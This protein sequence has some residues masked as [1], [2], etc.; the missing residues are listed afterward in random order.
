MTSS[1][2]RAGSRPSSPSSRTAPPRRSHDFKSSLVGRCSELAPRPARS[3][4]PFPTAGHR[5]RRGLVAIGGGAASAC[6][7]GVLALGVG[8]CAADRAAPAGHRPEPARRPG[9][10]RHRGRR[11]HRARS[12]LTLP[13]APGRAPRG[14]P[15]E[16]CS[17]SDEHQPDEQAPEPSRREP[18][19]EPARRRSRPSRSPDGAEPEPS[20]RRQPRGPALRPPRRRAAAPA[21]RRSAAPTASSRARA[22]RS[23][24]PPHRSHGPYSPGGPRRS[25][26]APAGGPVPGRSGVLRSRSATR[27][28]DYARPVP[29]RKLPLWVVARRGRPRAGRRPPRRPRRR[30]PAGRA[31]L[32]AR[33]RRQRPRRR[34]HPVRGAARR[35]QRVGAGR[36]AGAAAQ[37]RADRRRVRRPGGRRHRLRLRARPRGPRRHQQPRRRLGRRGRRPDRR[38]RPRGRAPRGHR[39][40]PQLGLRPRRAATSRT[41]RASSP[42]PWA[43]PRCC[44][45]ATRSSPSARRWG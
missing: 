32:A 5:P 42:P 10:P 37:H 29:P 3:P 30:R 43:R 28:A 34:T 24:Q 31:G 25:R 19:A 1:S 7:V 9:D 27:R 21:R 36:G 16:D 38:H 4:A 2:T 44:A 17:V 45:S 20:R 18:D 14:D 8:R 39:R 22:S 33:H 26:S 6:V 40:G 15:G 11:P 35:R 23:P 13:D 12:G 41:P